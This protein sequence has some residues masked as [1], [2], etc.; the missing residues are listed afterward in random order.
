M[1]SL[2]L[3]PIDQTPSLLVPS[4][5]DRHGVFKILGI[6]SIAVKISKRES[7][8]LFAVEISLQH[9]GGPA[10]HLHYEQDEWFYALEG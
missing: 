3:T 2:L 10:K 4:G 8:D 1:N 5:A 6:S 9:K 7:S